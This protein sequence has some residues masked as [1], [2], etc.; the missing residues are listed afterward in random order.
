LPLKK[1]LII[2]LALVFVPLAASAA[3][4]FWLGNARGN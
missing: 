2:F 1:H 3:R 4:Y